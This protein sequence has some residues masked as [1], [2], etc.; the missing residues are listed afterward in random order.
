MTLLLTAS[1]YGLKT[2]DLEAIV[3]NLSTIKG[4]KKAYLFGSRA[5]GNY[6][7]ASDVDI[8]VTG[9]QINQSSL[10]KVIDQLNEVEPI[11]FFIDLINF[12]EI[13]NEKLKQHIQN[14]GIVIF[15]A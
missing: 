15:E 11:P 14:F 8:A 7:E 13:T 2:R 1:M 6:K 4:I 12:D 5:L 10:L 3:Q 9:D